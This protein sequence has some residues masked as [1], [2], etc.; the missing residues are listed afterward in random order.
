VHTAPGNLEQVLVDLLATPTL[1]SKEAIVRRYD[2]EVR[3]GTLVRPFTGP[4]MDGPSDAA[5]LKPLG[6]WQ[7]NGAFALSV[8]IQ[9]QIGKVDPY[10]MAL[11]AVDEAVRNLVAVGADPDRVALLDNFCWGNPTLPDR[12]GSLVRACQGCHDAA[13]AYNAPFISGKDSLY[14]EFNGTPIPGTLLI[15]ALALTPDMERTVT[16]HFKAAGNRL[17]LLGETERTLAGSAYLAQIGAQGGAPPALPAEPL[18]RYRALHAA[19]RQG[20]VQSAHDLSEGGLAVALAEM[21]LAG[22]LGATVELAGVGA[23]DLPAD[24]RLFSET[25]GRLLVEVAAQDAPAF[26]AALDGQP[27]AVLGAVNDLAR[28]QI[29]LHGEGLVDVPVATLVAAW[30]REPLP[31]P[32]LEIPFAAPGFPT[33]NLNPEEPLAGA[34]EA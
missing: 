19:M 29:T 5:V 7:H 17:Y 15:S 13:L 2:H 32:D 4:Q 11:A 9:P 14:N 8:G 20:L 28:L 12:L 16:A 26:E 22:R 25:L 18:V 27:L 24:V 10:A 1:A 21:A 31:E 3:G 30:K 33:I 6:T 34:G 23:P